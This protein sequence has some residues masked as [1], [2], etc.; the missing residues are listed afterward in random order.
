MDTET[1]D[2]LAYL[3]H[4]EYDLN[5]FSGNLSVDEWNKL[6]QDEAKP[7]LDRVIHGAYP[8]GSVYKPILATLGLE[9]NT[10]EPDTKLASCEGGIFIGDRYFN[11]WWEKGHGQLNVTDAIKVSCDV[12]FYDLSTKFSLSQIGNFTKQNFLTVKTGI[13][14]PGE[15]SGFFPTRQWYID[16]YGKYA[17]IIGHKVNLAI[18]QGEILS[19]TLQICAYYAALANDGIWKQPHLMKKTIANNKNSFF[20]IHEE[21]LPVSEENL[22]LIQHALWKAV[23]ERYGTGTAASVA[24]VSIYGKTGSAENH[25]GEVTHSWFAGYAVNDRIKISFAVFLENA[26]HGGSVSAPIAGQIIDF[27]N[28]AAQ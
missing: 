28:K 1:G 14:L 6:N 22:H 21:Q 16:S 11:C 2:I 4:P 15:R 17:A 9:T 20:E 13:D 10:I 27:Y 12:F 25:M 19:T 7:M 26:G 18:G 24:G 8:P 5:I 3:S 23:N